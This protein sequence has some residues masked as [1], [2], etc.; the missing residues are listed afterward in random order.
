MGREGGREGEGDSTFTE[1]HTNKLHNNLCYEKR[2][3]GLGGRG[4]GGGGEGG[5]GGRG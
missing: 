3:R 4:K 2:G 5:R 1:Q